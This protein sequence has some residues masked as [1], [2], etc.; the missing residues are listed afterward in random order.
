M[1][2]ATFANLYSIVPILETGHKIRQIRK[3]KS[4][5]LMSLTAIKKPL[6]SGFGMIALVATGRIELPTLGL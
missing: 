2:E 5:T 6:C 1:Q 3:R 4:I